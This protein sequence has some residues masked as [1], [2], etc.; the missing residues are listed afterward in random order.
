LTI[1]LIRCI[2]TAILNT[3]DYYSLSLSFGFAIDAKRPPQPSHAS[4]PHRPSPKMQ[5]QNKQFTMRRGNRAWN[6]F[7]N[8][9]IL[10]V[11]IQITTSPVATHA[12][13]LCFKQAGYFNSR[14]WIIE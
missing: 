12:Y 14:Y 7:V 13:R 6:I 4:S 2:N 1:I 3:V 9:I 5:Y 10:W 11:I 8:T